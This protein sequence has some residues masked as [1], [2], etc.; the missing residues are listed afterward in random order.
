MQAGF[1]GQYMDGGTGDA[2]NHFRDYDPSIGRYLQSDPIGLQ[3][4]TNTF[5]YV[6]GNPLSWFA[7]F[8]FERVGRPYRTP[9]NSAFANVTRQQAA[10]TM[11]VVGDALTVATPFTGPAAPY[12]GGAATVFTVGS[13]ILDPSN[14]FSQGA[15]SVTTTAMAEFFTR[16]VQGPLDMGEAAV[17]AVSA[18]ADG[19][20][21]LAST[22]STVAESSSG[23]GAGPAGT[24]CAGGG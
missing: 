22:A 6:S 19:P 10:G 11:S 20:R 8:G 15:L 13:M 2:Y 24:C 23:A 14:N 12:V 3:G 18:A 4:G 5:A 9:E 7:F 17:K 1:P 21:A 16:K